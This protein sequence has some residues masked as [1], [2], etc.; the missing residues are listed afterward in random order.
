LE[1]RNPEAMPAYDSKAQ[2]IHVAPG[3]KV[4]IKLQLSESE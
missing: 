4:H 1:Y 3:E 2:V